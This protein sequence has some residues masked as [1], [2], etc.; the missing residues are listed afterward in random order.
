VSL[1]IFAF[2]ANISYNQ[3]SKILSP[4]SPLFLPKSPSGRLRTGAGSEFRSPVLPDITIN[5]KHLFNIARKGVLSPKVLEKALSI[6]GVIPSREDWAAFIENVLLMLGAA[7]F[8]TGVIFFFAYNWEDMHKFAKFAVVETAFIAAAAVVLITKIESMAGKAAAM[9]ASILTGVL[10]AVYGQV[11]QTGA[12]AYELFLVW[13]LF[14]FPWVMTSRFAPMYALLLVILNLTIGLSWHQ[15]LSGI[16]APKEAAVAELF[17]A[18]NVMALVLC[19]FF[20][21][22]GV[23][24]LQ[25]R[26]LPRVILCANLCTLS[27]ALL[28]YIHH[29]NGRASG[30]DLM[31]YLIPA[32][33]ILFV[34]A[35]FCYYLRVRYDL[36]A[37]TAALLSLIFVL[38]NIFIK[39]F[40][41]NAFN[42]F[43]GL[44]FVSFLVILQAAAAVILL[45]K[46]NQSRGDES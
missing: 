4:Q 33:Y 24:H 44:F 19:E 38:S 26:W 18:L 28:P 17:L 5:S 15:V 29:E 9:T 3:T 37:L 32:L 41:D 40:V 8:A 25:P 11:Y 36:F 16:F 23:E 21:R 14:I 31:P 6:I 13:S 46:I 27:M 7:L 43:I 35:A 1:K 22:R 20:S 30:A 39:I 42:N 34:S 12:D 2:S 45:R 10:L